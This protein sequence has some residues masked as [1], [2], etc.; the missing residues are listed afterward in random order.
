MRWSRE[1][2]RRR[3][4]QAIL[5]FL[6][7]VLIDETKKCWPW[8]STKNNY[9]YGQFWNGKRLV[10]AHRFA[11][12]MACGSVPEGLQLDHLCRNRACVN[13]SHLEAVTRRENLRRGFGC[14]G[15]NAK[16]THCP[17]GH[18]YGPDRRCRICRNSQ[19]REFKKRRAL[20]QS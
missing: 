3:E 12:E 17:R 10:G 18:E 11:Y 15:L 16:K 4:A 14:A 2:L 13:P 20:A 19:Q 5:N 8:T 6:D 1:D 9:G 7:K